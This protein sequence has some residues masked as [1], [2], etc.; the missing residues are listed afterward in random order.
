MIRAARSALSLAL[1]LATMACADDA[2][3]AIDLDLPDPHPGSRD[4]IVHLF[5]WP[6]ESIASECADQLGP[7]GFGAVQVS[8]PQEHVL[9]PD[10]DHPWWQDYQPVS[11]ALVTRR[12]D[13]A[14]FAAMVQAC[15]AAGVRVYVDAVIN[16]MAGGASTGPGS[17]GS[18]FTHYDYPSAGYGDDDFHHCAR[19]GTDDVVDWGDAYEVRNCELFD[20]ADLATGSRHVRAQLTAYLDD[21]MSLGVDGFR[22]DAAKHMPPGDL[23]A[24]F[25]ALAAPPVVFQEVIE[26]APGEI[27]PLQYR[28]TG[29]VTEFRYGDVVGG[30]FRDGDL[31]GL[32][33]L[34]DQ[35]L[36]DSDDAIVF[37]DNHDTQRNGRSPLTHVDGATYALAEAFM[38]A[39]PYGSPQLMSSFRFGSVDQGP[40]AD[41]AG[42][43]A[44]V[45]CADGWVCE[46]RWPTIAGMVGFHNQVHGTAVTDW[47]EDGDR[48]AFGRESAGFVVF[49]PRGESMTETFQTGLA[50][51]L[52][53]DVAGGAL[54]GEGCTGAEIEVASDGRFTATVEAGGMLAL[55]AGAVH[56]TGP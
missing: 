2:D 50:S 55:H 28:V 8:P 46:H 6:W 25:A 41:A 4:V 36:V 48:I 38:L 9:L 56:S 52:Y 44:P 13:R 29:D 31:A 11:Y 37:I 1:A 22:I 40:P 30:A 49:N 14:A 42:L 18:T 27:G 34:A 17:N 51:G 47:W 5:Q 26:G 54:D 23:A 19:N 33:R 10:L 39:W 7:L 45:D 32:D 15:H 53:C 16:H 24:I 20:L 3:P 12:G 21:L 35:M 43:T